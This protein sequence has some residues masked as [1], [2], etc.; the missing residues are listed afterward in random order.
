MFKLLNEIPLKMQIPFAVCLAITLPLTIVSITAIALNNN[1]IKYVN[2]DIELV[3]GGNKEIAQTSNNIDNAI[4]Q[5]KKKVR[6]LETELLKLQQMNIPQADK[7]IRAF[8]DVKPTIEAV[9]DI[10]QELQVAVDRDLELEEQVSDR[11][12]KEKKEH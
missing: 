11:I 6:D 3:I 1:E 10:N 12:K 9:E 7:A 2:E 8:N 5:Q 4:A